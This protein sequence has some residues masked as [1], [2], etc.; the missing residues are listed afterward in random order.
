MIT[1][2]EFIKNVED[3]V[4]EKVQHF[5]RNQKDYGPA[6]CIW[7]HQ[8]KGKVL[9][10]EIPMRPGYVRESVHRLC[11][12]DGNL[13]WV[14]DRKAINRWIEGEVLLHPSSAKSH[15]VVSP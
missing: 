5:T 4:F 13:K 15:K 1:L 6:P 8:L 9:F 2:M 3:E 7:V 14:P 11:N 10:D 12:L